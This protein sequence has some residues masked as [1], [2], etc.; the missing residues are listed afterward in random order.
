MKWINW[1]CILHILIDRY[2]WDSLFRKTGMIR[3]WQRYVPD[4]LLSKLGSIWYISLFIKT[5][6]IAICYL[7]FPFL[8]LICHPIGITQASFFD[9]VSPEWMSIKRDMK[10]WQNW[11]GQLLVGSQFESIGWSHP[12]I[13]LE[14]GSWF[15]QN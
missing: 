7:R 14:D 11:I 4:F 6:Y 12:F 1:N 8:N 9:D 10:I 15:C 3:K 5:L 2:G 13:G